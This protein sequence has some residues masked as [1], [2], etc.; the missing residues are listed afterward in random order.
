MSFLQ[1]YIK[2]REH[3]TNIVE[4]QV[5][6]QTDVESIESDN[7]EREEEVD[8][9]ESLDAQ[10]QNFDSN[11]VSLTSTRFS[12]NNSPSISSQASPRPLLQ[13]NTNRS[14]SNTTSQKNRKTSDTVPH[15][16]KEYIDNKKRKDLEKEKKR[17]AEP[18]PLMEFFINMARTTETFPP[19]LQAQVKNKVF[20]TVNSIELQTLT[21]KSQQR[22]LSFTVDP[23]NLGSHY[24]KNVSTPHYELFT[25]QSTSV[26]PRCPPHNL[27]DIS[28]AQSTSVM[29]S[30]PPNNALEEQP[31]QTTPYFTRL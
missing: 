28:T 18:T 31:V 27:L 29:P 5:T 9:T 2:G 12:Q 19:H 22:S 6:E 8:G 14:N 11:L 17:R 1:P 30:F 7:E 15:L 10:T 23:P 21:E 26:M 13:E 3:H 24:A 20:Q 16:F 25:A 4:E